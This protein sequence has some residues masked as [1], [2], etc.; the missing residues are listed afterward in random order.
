MKLPF[1]PGL[2]RQVFMSSGVKRVG[3]ERG[4]GLGEGEKKKG[5]S[6]E[7]NIKPRSKEF[8]NAL[9]HGNLITLGSKL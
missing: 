6:V 7:E 9:G 4:G 1:S 5:K 2:A 3:G 8:Y